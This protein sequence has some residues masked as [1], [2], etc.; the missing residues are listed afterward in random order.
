MFHVVVFNDLGKSKFVIVVVPLD[1]KYITAGFSLSVGSLQ[2]K[3]ST[4]IS[5]LPTVYMCPL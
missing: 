5:E 4:L 3:L 2:N 1:F